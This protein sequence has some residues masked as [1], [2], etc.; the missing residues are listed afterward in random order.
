[1]QSDG[2]FVVYMRTLKDTRALWAS[3]TGGQGHG[4]YKLIN[5]A[6][7]N[8]V[9]YDK[10]K[11]LWATATNGKNEGA[12]T[13]VMQQDGNLVLY[14]SKTA[15]WASASN[16][17]V[18]ATKYHGKDRVA[19]NERLVEGASITS[20][21]GQFVTVVQAD[22]NF[23]LYHGSKALWA[24]NTGGKGS[25]ASLEVQEDH[26]VVL[27]D[28]KGTALW[29]SNTNGKGQAPVYLVQQD[30]GN[31]VLYDGH[32]KAVWASNT[33]QNTSE[34]KV[35]GVLEQNGTLQSSNKHYRLI[36]QADGN[37]VV[38]KQDT[39]IWASNTTGKGQAPYKL[40]NQNDGNLVLYDHADKPHWATSTNGKSS[41]QHLSMQDDGNLV[42]YSGNHAIWASNTN[43]K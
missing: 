29:A 9:L 33:V 43:G 11:A 19:L 14:D 38:Y 2:N 16:H 28:S 37:L 15:I 13:L 3:N 36:V 31:L 7:G 23:V 41:N 1:V 26:N 4:P 5:Q 35:G 25:G 22:G 39:A 6:D 18:K 27:Y 40:I 30:D 20:S 17:E 21:N 42:L 8:L 10:E 24:S 32:D 34:L 12:T